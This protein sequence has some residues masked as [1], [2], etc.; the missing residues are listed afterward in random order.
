MKTL[1]K[2]PQILIGI[3]PV[4]LL[5]L[6]SC[7]FQ[8]DIFVTTLFSNIL[9]NEEIVLSAII[10]AVTFNC[11]IVFLFL[12]AILGKRLNLKYMYYSALIG[13]AIPAISIVISNFSPSSGTTL[14]Y[15]FGLTIGLILYPFGRL[16]NFSFEGLEH[17]YWVY[18]DKYIF[19]YS[20]AINITVISLISLLFF[21]LI[22]K[23]KQ[24]TTDN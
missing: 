23:K 15:L 21:K 1:K 20:F 12:C 14:S 5:W 13:V 2:A 11:M 18:F 10:P 7:I 22:R 3:I 19:K 6:I 9:K 17:F 4:M 16:A 8:D 24:L